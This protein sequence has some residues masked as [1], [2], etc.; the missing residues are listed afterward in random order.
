MSRAAVLFLVLN[1]TSSV[2][3]QQS[4]KP[5]VITAI[6][7][8]TSRSMRDLMRGVKPVLDTGRQQAL[9]MEEPPERH[10]P[11]AFDPVVQNAP[12]VPQQAQIVSSF[13]GITLGGAVPPDTN[14]S[15]GING[16]YVQTTNF[17][18]AVFDK[19]TG[20]VT[21]GPYYVKSLFQG[22]GGQCETE[23]SMS[24]PTVRFDKAAGRWI[25]QQI[26]GDW[27][28]MPPLYICL[29][30]STTSDAT[31][32]YYR[33]SIPY[34]NYLPD[35]PKLSVWPDAYY[36][37]ADLYLNWNFTASSACA[38]DRT[39]MLQGGPA[40][41]ICFQTDTSVFHF[42]PADLD[43]N[44]P[45]PRG[46]PNF[47]VG[48]V[49]GANNQLNLFK[50]HVDFGNPQ[51][52]TFTGPFNIPVAPYTVACWAD[53]IPQPGTSTTLYGLGQMTMYRLAYR[54]F[55]P[56]TVPSTARGAAH[57][58]IV[59]THTV[60]NNDGSYGIRWYEL[61]ALENRDF[62]VYQQ[63]TFAP[64]S[65]SRWMGSVAMDKVGDMAM[66]YSIS[67]S[68]M[69][70]SINFTGRL[71]TD[72]LSTMEQESSIMSGTASQLDSDRWGDYSSMVPDPADDCRLW[73]TTEYLS[74][75]QNWRTRIV[76]LKFPSCH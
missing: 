42:L 48:N 12:G 70:P 10:V 56:P 8:D 20:N 50:F 40:S 3:A 41:A 51:N 9:D 67:S 73:Y 69:Y 76:S 16:Q 18:Y 36:L 44:A 72:P 26:A 30:V 34:G 66:G 54:N 37:T 46:T 15:P 1:L 75:S 43:G 21:F 19:T 35:Y 4:S 53:C 49:G 5:V 32:S 59:V 13:E 52:S 71:V 22:F 60:Q 38:L 17:L 74:G 11:R 39:A 55:V 28:F 47:I 14:G 24:D 33:Y 31:G 25:I 45:P 27:G 23:T 6:R 65:N 58:S 61:R 7:H 63:S 62:T 2:F 68:T 57:Q 29:A 64:D